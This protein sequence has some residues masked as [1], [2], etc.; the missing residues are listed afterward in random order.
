MDETARTT[1]VAS[2]AADVSWRRRFDIPAISQVTWAGLAPHRLGVV[3]TESG[4]SQA[5]AWDLKTGE[6]RLASQGGV[7]AE[8]VHMTPDGSGVVWW[9]D[10]TGDERGHWMR[11]PFEGGRAEP[12]IPGIPDGWMMGI[13][14]VAGA[15]AVGLSLED[16]YS[17]YVSLDGNP[18]REIYRHVRPAG[19]GLEW[20]QG[21]GGLSIDGSLVYSNK[22]H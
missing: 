15:T 4:S 22:P 18:A 11:T 9:L 20:P 7:G 19:V 16:G 1:D 6:R 17:V 14:L 8:E 10:V 2:P 3:S 5:W 13:S 21:P 12:L